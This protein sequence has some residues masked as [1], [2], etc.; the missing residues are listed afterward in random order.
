MK[1]F[2]VIDGERFE[3]VSETTTMSESFREARDHLFDTLAA[4]GVDLDGVDS[5]LINQDGTYRL[6]R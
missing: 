4:A 1:K 6:V 3:V 5:I 2:E